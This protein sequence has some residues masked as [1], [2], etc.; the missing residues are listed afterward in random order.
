MHKGFILCMVFLESI[1][2]NRLAG[3]Q[4]TVAYHAKALVEVTSH[5]DYPRSEMV[6]IANAASASTKE[7]YLSTTTDP[8]TLAKELGIRGFL[9]A[10]RGDH[11]GAIA[12]FT[13]ALELDPSNT[14]LYYNRGISRAAIGDHSGAIADFTQTIRRDPRSADAYFN[15]GL[16][17]TITQNRQAAIADFTQ[18]IYIY[19]VHAMMNALLGKTPTIVPNANLPYI[20]YNRGKAWSAAGVTLAGITDL[21]RAALLAQ[22]TGDRTLVQLIQTELRT[23]P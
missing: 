14:D 15:R 10:D 2:A 23:P 3:I 21:R 16:V 9:K 17:Y 8:V 19:E 7:N 20:Y 5:G 1:Q 4:P 18:A 22:Q 11:R 13:R 6:L 12:D